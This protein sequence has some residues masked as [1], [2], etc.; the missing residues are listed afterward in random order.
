[1]NNTFNPQRFGLLF[2]KTLLE[3]PMQMF[4]F[5]GLILALILILYAIIKTISGFNVAQNFTFLWGLVGGS[6]FMASFVFSHFFSNAIGSS[7][8]TL[9]ASHF[10]KWLCGIL[11]AGILYP[12][13]FIL[14][15]RLMDASFV[16]V[17]HNGLDPTAPFYKERYQSVNVLSFNGFFAWKV[18]PMFLFGV[19]AMLTGSLYFNKAGLIKVSLIICGLLIS[20]YLINHLFAKLVFGGNIEDA[21]PFHYVMIPVGKAEG[22]VLLPEKISDFAFN[23]VSYVFP[24]ILFITSFIRLREKEF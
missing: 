17:Y 16:S 15:Y 22:S 5:T 7:F 6:Y 13:I 3:K 9:P 2:K 8:L 10:E 1:M 23:V 24:A 20:L 4:G 19:S 21:W 11:I 18:Y 12:A 14:F